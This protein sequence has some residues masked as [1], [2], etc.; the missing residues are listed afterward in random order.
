MHIYC[1]NLIFIYPTHKHLFCLF[2]SFMCSWFYLT[3]LLDIVYGWLCHVDFPLDEVGSFDF[4]F[5]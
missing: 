2:S 5:V 1:N 3:T 4:I